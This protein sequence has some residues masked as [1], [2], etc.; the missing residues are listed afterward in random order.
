MNLYNTLPTSFNEKDYKKAVD[1]LNKR[2]KRLSKDSVY[3]EFSNTLESIQVRSHQVKTGKVKDR[4]F[5]KSGNIATS[6]R[7]LTEAE[8][9]QNYQRV[10][11]Y[12]MKSDLKK[13][14]IKKELKKKAEKYNT[15]IA[16]LIKDRD[17]WRAYNAID[18]E[19]Q[20]ESTEIFNA[21]DIV[22]RNRGSL[23][24]LELKK[25]AE[26]VLD[27]Y[28]TALKKHKKGRSDVSKTKKVNYSNKTLFEKIALADTKSIRIRHSKGRKK[29]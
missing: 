24:Y 15:T 9:L 12:L 21:I 16:E 29:L 13:T 1:A 23:S 6:T 20:Y 3:S 25:E 7:G 10:V 19:T 8:K 17:F 5:T 27:S 14:T 2:I 18:E 26:S 22:E 28:K 11:K 4:L